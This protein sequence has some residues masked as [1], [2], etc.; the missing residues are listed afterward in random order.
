MVNGMDISNSEDSHKEHCIPCLKG[1]QNCAVIPTESDVESPR[2]LHRMYLDI[3]GPMETT[4]WRGFHYFIMF[5]D[6]Y[7]HCLVVK[8]IKLKSDM[9]KLTKKYLERAEAETGEHVN[10]FHSDGGD[11][12]GLKALQ[13]YF[14]SRGIHHEMMNMYTPQE[15][16]V[17]E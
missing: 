5:I 9:P 4:A 7:S 3:C 12:Y 16:G 6:G 11:E 14:K 13:D 8:L 1:K 15:N 10:Y 2:V 17:S